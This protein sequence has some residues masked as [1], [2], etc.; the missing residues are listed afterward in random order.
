MFTKSAGI[1]L[2][3]KP[4]IYQAYAKEFTSLPLKLFE[5]NKQ[6]RLGRGERLRLIS[7]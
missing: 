1:L 5:A 2:L 3:L 4:K 7:V 6:K